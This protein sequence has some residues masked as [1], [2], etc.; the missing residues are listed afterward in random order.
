M[1]LCFVWIEMMFLMF[2]IIG[3]VMMYSTNVVP[4]K[5][6]N[7]KVKE[8]INSVSPTSGTAEQNA[9]LMSQMRPSDEVVKYVDL[10]CEINGSA[11][12]CYI[13]VTKERLIFKTATVG[14]SAGSLNDGLANNGKPSK[15]FRFD[16][17]QETA[18]IPIAKV[19]SMAMSTQSIRLVRENFSDKWTYDGPTLQAHVLSINAQGLQSKLF[20]GQLGDVAT[21]FSRTFISMTYDREE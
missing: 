3:G 4:K 17:K 2:A 21:E 9:E 7:R 14:D 10:K 1:D 6:Y 16:M 18:N 8:F 11:V 12:N 13:A 20:L 15:D 5:E 19:T